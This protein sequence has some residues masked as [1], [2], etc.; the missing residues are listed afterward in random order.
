MNLCKFY[1]ATRGA[2]I[3]SKASKLVR[4]I[5]LIR[6][7]RL[8]KLYKSSNTIIA[9]EDE[10]N[11]DEEEKVIEQ[12][13]DEE[14]QEE[15][16]D[17]I[18]PEESKIGK[19]LSDITTK[20]VIVMVLCVMLSV[21]LFTYSTYCDDSLSYQVGIDY[22]TLFDSNPTGSGFN[23]AYKSYLNRHL[24]IETPIIYVVAGP[25]SYDDTSVDANVIRNTE[26]TTVYPTSDNLNLTYIAMFDIRFATHMDAMLSILQTIFV[27]FV[28][29]IGAVVFLKMLTI[30]L[31]DQLSK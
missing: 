7:L 17:P 16:K 22:I 4:V 9:K 15:G 18:L 6:L 14:R 3:G 21:P 5:R 28:L 13:M 27:C 1:R 11:I 8:V 24:S 12:M 2:R 10:K 26:E 31:L 19:S 30:L 25:Y 20:T 23:T 29:T